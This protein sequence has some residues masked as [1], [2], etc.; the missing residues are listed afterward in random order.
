M[1]RIAVYTV[2]FLGVRF[3]GRSGKVVE[4]NFL[5]KMLV[6]VFSFLFKH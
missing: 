5:G 2:L 1:L 6:Y 4:G 3:Q